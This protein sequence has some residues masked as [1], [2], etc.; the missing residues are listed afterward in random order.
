MHAYLVGSAKVIVLGVNSPQ[1]PHGTDAG[2][3]GQH[4]GHSAHEL[5]RGAP[6]NPGVVN[7]EVGWDHGVDNPDH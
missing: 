3:E 4:E 2:H 7:E 5:Q 1:Q 6:P